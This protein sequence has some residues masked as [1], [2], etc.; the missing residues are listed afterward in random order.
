MIACGWCGGQEAAIMVLGT[1]VVF[2]A[3]NGLGWVWLQ[4]C[5]GIRRLRKKTCNP[6]N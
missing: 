2:G 6:T 5:R 1:G 3:V 4:V